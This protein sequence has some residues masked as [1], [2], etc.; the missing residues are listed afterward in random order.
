VFLFPA[1]HLVQTSDAQVNATLKTYEN[2]NFGL[3]LT[4]PSTWTV[5]ELRDD[6]E[7]PADNSIVAIFK[8]ESQDANDKYLENIIINVQGPNSDLK[9]LEDYTR[10]SIRDFNQMPDI[11]ITKS[12]KNTLSGFPAHVLEYTS[13][14]A[15]PAFQEL[16]LKKFQVFTVVNKIAYVVTY[17]AEQAEYDKNISDVE[18]LIKSIKIDRDAIG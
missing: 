12:G 15:T 1:I 2:P 17:G 9:S 4:Y 18:N 7:A 11:H 3:T 5:D 16:N 8:S 6:P 10:D 13:R 14:L